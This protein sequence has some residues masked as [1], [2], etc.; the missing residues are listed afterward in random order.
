MKTKYPIKVA[1]QLY[2]AGTEVRQATLAEMQQVFPG[3]VTRR[4]S[5]QAGVWFPDLTHP[6]II[7]T[8]QLDGVRYPIQTWN[9]PANQLTPLR[10]GEGEV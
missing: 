9:E 5:P 3:I 8:S 1:G 10:C 7:H 6:T 4:G 2:P